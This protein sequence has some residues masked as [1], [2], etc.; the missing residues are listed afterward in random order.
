MPSRYKISILTFVFTFSFLFGLV[1]RGYAQ[2]ANPATGA[3]LSVYT[4]DT[5]SSGDIMVLAEGGKYF[6]SIKTYDER[7][8]GVVTD[9][10]ALSIEDTL[11]TDGVFVTSGGEAFVNVSTINGPIKKGDFITSSSIPGV[12]QKADVSG[13]VLGIAL[14]DYN[15]ESSEQVGDILVQIDVKPNVVSDV[16]VNLIEAWRKGTQ[17]PYL[18]PLTSLR[19]VLAALVTGGAFVIGFASFGKTSGSG[20]EALGRNPLAHKTIERG[21]V[22]NMLLTAGIML[23]GLVLAYLILVL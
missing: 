6:K 4:E 12:G 13:Q 7:M 2:L 11:L 5:V 20:V 17:A 8:F 23:A 15:V 16:K 3:A 9:A 18:T 22:F 10:P 1:N 19:Y 14:Q 21:I